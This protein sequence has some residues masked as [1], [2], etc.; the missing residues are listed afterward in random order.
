M[1]NKKAPKGEQSREFKIYLTGGNEKLPEI[2]FNDTKL[3]GVQ[4]LVINTSSS[5]DL[6]CTIK[7]SLTKCK[8]SFIV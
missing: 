5:G 4:E 7:I 8:G 2:F 6:E 1:D 3:P